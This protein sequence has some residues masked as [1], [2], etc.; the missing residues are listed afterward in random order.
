MMP[1]PERASE[2]AL[3]MLDGLKIIRS[4]VSAPANATP[5]FAAGNAVALK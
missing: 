1:H 3:G 2:P 5:V 4:L